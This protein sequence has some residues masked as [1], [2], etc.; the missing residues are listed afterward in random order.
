[1][2]AEKK[3]ILFFCLIFYFSLLILFAQFFHKEEPL[4]QMPM[5]QCPVCLWQQ[6]TITLASLYLL[7]MIVIFVV[8]SHI[9]FFNE[10]I[11]FFLSF[12]HYLRRAPPGNL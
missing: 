4:Q 1:M 12:Y 7:C 11:E 6:N 3:K 8:F 10:K 9:A 5:G 2:K